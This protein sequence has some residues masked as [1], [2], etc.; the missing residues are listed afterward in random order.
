MDDATIR[1]EKRK[2]YVDQFLSEI[3]VVHNALAKS[4]HKC[5]D[6]WARQVQL[7]TDQPSANWGNVILHLCRAVESQLASS[8]GQVQGLEFLAGN[9][10]LGPKSQSL[11]R[12]KLDSA[13]KQRLTARGIKPG[14]VS[15][16]FPEILR[17]LAELRSQTDAAHGG[18]EIRSATIDDAQQAR[19][20]TGIVLRGI[21]WQSSKGHT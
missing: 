9:T 16:K 17:G 2:E 4:T 14:F 20:L 13:V 1:Q 3:G 7:V 12:A 10:P 8:L 5:L 19:H 11:Q 15:S 18:L 6:D 21:A